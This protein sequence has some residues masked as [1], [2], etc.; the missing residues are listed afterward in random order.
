MYWTSDGAYAAA[1]NRTVDFSL[2]LEIEML[3]NG[4]DDYSTL[5]TRIHN[6]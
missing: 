2:S 5:E 1:G 4:F 6:A 3:D